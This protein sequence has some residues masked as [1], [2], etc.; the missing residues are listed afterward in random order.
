MKK[1]SETE[2]KD[3]CKAVDTDCAPPFQC[4]LP[5]GHEGPHEWKRGESK[6]QWNDEKGN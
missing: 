4:E 1:N 5:A 6:K 3:R 2:L